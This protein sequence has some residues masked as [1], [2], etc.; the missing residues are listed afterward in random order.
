MLAVTVSQ[1]PSLSVTL[2]GTAALAK[3]AP[4]LANV[5]TIVKAVNF[6]RFFSFFHPPIFFFLK[7]N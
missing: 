5:E 6:L 7:T 4:P 3:I 2:S 1:T